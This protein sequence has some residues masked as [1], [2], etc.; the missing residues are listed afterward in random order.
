MGKKEFFLNTG[1]RVW[2]NTDPDP[3]QTTLHSLARDGA[4]EE[5]ISRKDAMARLVNTK[6]KWGRTPLHEAARSNSEDTIRLLA[7]MGADLEAMDDDIQTPL[8][9]AAA[10][11]KHRSV[12]ELILCGASLFAKDKSGSLPIHLAASCTRGDLLNLLSSSGDSTILRSADQHGTL[13]IHYAAS[14]DNLEAVRWYVEHGLSPT[15]P[16]AGGNAL[17]FHALLGKALRVLG[18]L[19]D[20]KIDWNVRSEAGQ[21]AA[22][23]AKIA[24]PDFDPFTP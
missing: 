24:L 17:V 4:Y 9:H 19:V 3:L 20:Q 1:D 5:I 14:S 21:S 12:S 16:D 18:Y 6:D 8:H 13:P 22:E 10:F 23:F 11:E 15:E 7:G 2:V